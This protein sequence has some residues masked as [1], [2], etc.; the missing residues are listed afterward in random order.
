MLVW[1]A[2]PHPHPM[3]FHHQVTREG[4]SRPAWH[5]TEVGAEGIERY[6]TWCLSPRE[7]SGIRDQPEK[8]RPPK[9]F[10]HQFTMDIKKEWTKAFV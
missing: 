3:C 1:K 2:H 5:I 7:F 4:E 6:G 8:K 9:A 10:F